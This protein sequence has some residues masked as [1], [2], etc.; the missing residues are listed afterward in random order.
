VTVKTDRDT[1]EIIRQ[2]GWKMLLV[3]VLLTI[4]LLGFVC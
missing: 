2:E 1:E 4:A 3:I